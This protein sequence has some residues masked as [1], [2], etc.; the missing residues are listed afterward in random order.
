MV[1]YYHRT[2]L[3]TQLEYL[4]KQYPDERESNRCSKPWGPRLFYTSVVAVIGHF[5]LNHG[6]AEWKQS[7]LTPLIA[8]AVGLPALAASLRIHRDTREYGR[9]SLRHHATYNA[10]HELSDQLM[11]EQSPDGIFR[12]VGLCEQILESDTREWTRLFSESEWFG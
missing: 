9:N 3:S 11:E 8:V 10:L 4:N 7:W 1:R 12:I 2:R 5:L 6:S